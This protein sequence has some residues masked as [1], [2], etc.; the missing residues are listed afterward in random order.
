[1]PLRVCEADLRAGG[2]Y[3]YVF[4]F[5]DDA[6]KSTEFTG[7]SLEVTPHSR[8]VGTSDE[9]GNDSVATATFEERGG[10]TLLVVSERYPSKEALDEAV[11][12]MEPG[13]DEQYEQLGELIVALAAKN[14]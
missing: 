13:T 10:K 1:M 6:S 7:Q 3:R 12:G 8:L 5:D 2:R 14:V 9:R 4:G 11:A